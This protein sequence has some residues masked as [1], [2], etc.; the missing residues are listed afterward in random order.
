M[1]LGSSRNGKRDQTI[2]MNDPMDIGQLVAEVACGNFSHA[3]L[4]KRLAGLVGGLAKNPKRGLPR[5]FDS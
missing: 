3:R 2:G 5:C 4:N 1:S